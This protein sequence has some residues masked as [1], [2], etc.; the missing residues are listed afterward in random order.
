[1]CNVAEFVSYSKNNGGPKKIFKPKYYDP[2][3][4]KVD[5]NN[6]L[7]PLDRNVTSYEEG[8]MQLKDFIIQRGRWLDKHIETLK[9]YAHE[10]RVKKFNH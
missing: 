10:S 5:E 8:I 2:I 6:R 4:E 1:M 9:Q 3:S 7:A